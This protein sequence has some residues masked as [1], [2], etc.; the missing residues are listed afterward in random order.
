MWQN[1][2]KSKKQIRFLRSCRYRGNVVIFLS[3]ATI[4]TLIPGLGNE[5]FSLPS[6]GY[7]T[8]RR[9]SSINETPERRKVINRVY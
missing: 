7:K 6:S 1:E 3:I 9:V 5:L 8:I 2:N 4:V